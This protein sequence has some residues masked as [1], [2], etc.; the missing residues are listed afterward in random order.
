MADEIT[1]GIYV[2]SYKRANDIVTW[3]VLDGNCTYVVRKSEEEAYLSSGV[4]NVIGVDDEL[5]NSA[6]KVRYWI[7][8]NRPEDIIVQIDDDV[9]EFRRCSSETGR[10]STYEVMDEIYRIAQVMYDLKIGYSGTRN[11]A[12]PFNYVSEFA[13]S[14]VVGTFTFFNKDVFKA[15]PDPLASYAEDTDRV[16]QELLKN[17]IILAPL[18]L[19]TVHDMDTAPG[20]D[21][22]S[23]TGN[24]LK[25]A[26]DYLS[27]KWGKYYSYNPTNNKSSI[28][29]KR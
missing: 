27:Q 6:Q 25:S 19:S 29:V 23:K 3:N 22:D 20:G 24:K 18:Y 2:P 5:I 7:L 12:A 26:R 14:G 21:S 8:E 28:H 9:K 11:T 16:L 10:L 1:V 4:E 17:R 15:K 13:F